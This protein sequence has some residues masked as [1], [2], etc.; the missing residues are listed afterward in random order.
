MLRLARNRP[1]IREPRMRRKDGTGA[2]RRRRVFRRELDIVVVHHHHHHLAP[3][4]GVQPH[5]SIPDLPS[6]EQHRLQHLPI[7]QFAYFV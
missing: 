1:S 5:L 3:L 2:A 7:H 6:P 4:E